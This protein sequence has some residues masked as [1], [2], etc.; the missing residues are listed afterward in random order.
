MSISATQGS[1]SV[2]NTI[3]NQIQYI[4]NNI[5]KTENKQE[6]SKQIENAQEKLDNALFYEKQI[7]INEI[8]LCQQRLD[9]IKNIFEHGA[10]SPASQPPSAP[11]PAPQS[12]SF[13]QRSFNHV[14]PSSLPTT[15]SPQQ[16]APSPQ[17]S[18]TNQGF[19]STLPQQPQATPVSVDVSHVDVPQLVSRR[20]IHHQPPAK[21]PTATP[22]ATPVFSVLTS[23]VQTNVQPQRTSTLSPQEVL[24]QNQSFLEAFKQKD[25]I[26]YYWVWFN[27]FP[28]DCYNGATKTG[29]HFMTKE[30]QGEF[31]T[32]YNALSQDKLRG[33]FN[34][35]TSFQPLLMKMLDQP[36]NSASSDSLMNNP[37]FLELFNLYNSSLSY[38]MSIQ[39]LPSPPPR[40]VMSSQRTFQPTASLPPYPTRLPPQPPVQLPTTT[41]TTT[42]Q[43]A[44]AP[45]VQSSLQPQRTSTLSPQEVLK[46]NLDFLTFFELKDKTSYY[47][48]WFTHYSVEQFT[49]ITQTGTL[50][51]AKFEKE[52]FQ[53]YFYPRSEASLSGKFNFQEQFKKYFVELQE[54]E[55]EAF[56]TVKRPP[57][58]ITQ[59]HG[60][61]TKNPIFLKL[62]EIYDNFAYAQVIYG[63]KTGYPI[64]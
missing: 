62:L 55:K 14:A 11:V 59:K 31:E 43:V 18:T 64:F 61:L 26:S 9:R 38:E 21:Q 63:R 1:N 10:A 34:F 58:E 37:V 39:N 7:D 30:E 12:Q 3:E 42:T 54:Q 25:P 20:Y 24:T 51:M 6:L 47:C 40:S 57:N 36:R 52:R 17:P 22:T 41:T 5:G 56:S 29:S 8:S 2:I 13:P 32:E 15:P 4:E 60:I 53:D 35:A 33:K 48:T 44:L 28:V 49:A 23:P 46:K 50:L 16:P 27:H 45:P 19:R